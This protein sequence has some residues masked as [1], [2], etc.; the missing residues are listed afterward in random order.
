MKLDT[1]EGY[2]C[3]SGGI[4]YLG[5]SNR[6]ECIVLPTYK[7]LIAL[8]RAVL[9]ELSPELAARIYR[10]AATHYNGRELPATE[11]HFNALAAAAEEL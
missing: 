6:Y 3:P 7:E 2:P 4:C 8:R 1:L 9:G 5:C 11:A 10:G